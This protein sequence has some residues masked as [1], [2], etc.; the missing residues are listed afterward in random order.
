MKAL[1]EDFLNYLAVER[2]LAKNSLLAYRRDLSAYVRYLEGHC[3][4]KDPSVVRREHV[5]SYMQQQKKGGLSSSSIC[6]S[7]AAVRM[8]HRFLVR[9]NI[10]VEDPTDLV[11]TPKLWKRVPDVLTQ[12]EVEQMISLAGGRDAQA[13][14]DRAMLEL[15]YASGLRVSELAG[16][17]LESVN[18]QVG[19]VRCL[20]K[21]SKERIIPV[22]K[23]AREALERYLQKA[24][25]RLLGGRASSALFLSRLGT[26][27]TRQALWK[28]IKAYAAKAGI[29]KTI[30][31]HTLRHTFATHLLEH[32]ADLRS[33]QEML[34]HAD[35]STTQIYTH[36]DRERLRTIHKQFHPRG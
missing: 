34:G 5:T 18:L 2:G 12:A 6:R 17:S 11:D 32:G 31:P 16:L 29:K 26:P 28:I 15:F 4:L 33:V 35:I 36:V 13:V 22:G 3:H 21:G 7:L 24:R 10:V 25:A 1:V 19:F 8:F 23:G 30:K 20:G 9:E 27:L 14:R